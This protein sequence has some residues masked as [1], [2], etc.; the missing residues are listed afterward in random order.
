MQR[1]INAL[2]TLFLKNG[3]GNELY[4]KWLQ[5]MFLMSMLLTQDGVLMAQIQLHQHVM[6]NGMDFV[7]CSLL[8]FKIL[9]IVKTNKQKNS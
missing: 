5:I 7:F 3:E 8:V 9:N 1:T 6:Q 2:Y 4:F